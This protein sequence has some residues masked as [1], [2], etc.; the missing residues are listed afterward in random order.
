M[1]LLPRGWKSGLLDHKIML[2]H[3][4]AS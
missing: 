2:D 4:V 3:T 1:Q